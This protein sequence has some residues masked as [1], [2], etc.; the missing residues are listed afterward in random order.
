MEMLRIYICLL[1]SKPTSKEQSTIYHLSWLSAFI[2]FSKMF[3]FQTVGSAASL[4]ILWPNL[5]S[6][7]RQQFHQISEL[8][9]QC[10]VWLVLCSSGATCQGVCTHSIISPFKGSCAGYSSAACHQTTVMV[11]T[12]RM[13]CSTERQ[14]KAWLHA[15]AKGSLSSQHE[16]WPTN[17]HSRLV[18]WLHVLKRQ[19]LKRATLSQDTRKD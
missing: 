10:H 19:N 17:H 8:L 16:I 7:C 13:R 15:C 5:T 3:S 12:G 4:L 18:K 14:L 9:F 11:T 1:T 2:Y 6:A